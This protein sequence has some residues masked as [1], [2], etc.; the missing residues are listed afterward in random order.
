MAK[1][2]IQGMHMDRGGLHKSL[3]VPAGKR[4]PAKMLDAAKNSKNP[5]TRRQANLAATLGRLRGR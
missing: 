5:K 3:G 2:W 4:I 1:Q